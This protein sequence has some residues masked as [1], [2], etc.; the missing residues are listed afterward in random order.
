MTKPN[1]AHLS[2]TTESPDDSSKK[3]EEGNMSE[4]RKRLKTRLTLQRPTLSSV[5]DG[6]YII[7]GAAAVHLVPGPVVLPLAIA[8]IAVYLVWSLG[9]HVILYFRRKRS[10][11]GRPGNC[12]VDGARARWELGGGPRGDARRLRELKMSTAGPGS[13]DLPVRDDHPL[14]RHRPA[15]P[16]QA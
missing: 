8:L 16:R 15:Q 11:S 4:D 14:H 9:P 1:G 2:E 6:V 10:G 3:G 7:G 5:I 12:P 13:P